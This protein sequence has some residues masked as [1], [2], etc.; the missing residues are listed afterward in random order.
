[1]ERLN[2]ERGDKPKFEL[3]RWEDDYYTADST[4]QEQIVKSSD[5]DIVICIFWKR[6]GS[7]L[8]DQ[9][10]RPDGTNPTGT[11]YEFEMAIE[12][13]S[14]S[15]VR[16]PSLLVYRKTAEVFFSERDLAVERDQY[17]RFKAFW[18]RWFRNEKAHFTAG[19][20]SYDSL[21]AFEELVEAHIHKWL[22]DRRKEVTWTRGSPFVGL[23]AFSPEQAEVFFGR[24][25]ETDRVRARFIAN[26]IA[27]SKFLLVQGPSGSGKS[28]LVRA[29]V[30]PRLR[31]SDPVTGLPDLSMTVEITPADLLSGG[32]DWQAGLASALF[33]APDLGATLAE[34]DFP[35]PGAL[36]KGIRDRGV[37][38]AA[39][40]GALGR[41][42]AAAGRTMGLLIVLDQLEEVFDWP[43]EAA[44][45][46]FA[47]LGPLMEDAPVHTIATMRSEYQHRAAGLPPLAA[48]LGLDGLRDPGA[49]V[50]TIS[51]APP[52]PA[53]LREMI[54]APAAAAGLTYEGTKADRPPLARRIEEAVRVTALPALQL[55]LSELYE[56]RSDMMLTHDA[57]DALG[58]VSGVMAN[59]GELTLSNV[60]A[61]ERAALPKLMRNLVRTGGEG[62]PVV[63]A[64]LARAR[65]EADPAAAGLVKQLMDAGLIVGDETSIRLAHEMLIDAWERLRD[66]VA[67]ERRYIAIRDRLRSLHGAYLKADRKASGLLSGLA[68]DEAVELRNAWGTGALDSHGDGLEDFLRA[69]V[70]ARWRRLLGV[71]MAGI[72]AVLLAAMLGWSVVEQHRAQTT[73]A[74]RAD[75]LAVA[76]EIRGKQPGYRERAASRALAAM[77][78][79]ATPETLAA[80]I[81]A[82]IEQPPQHNLLR[83]PGEIAA[84]TYLPDHRL[85]TIDVAGTLRVDGRPAGTIDIGNSAPRIIAALGADGFVV[86]TSN[87]RV[88]ISPGGLRASQPA[89]HWVSA[90]A[91]IDLARADQVVVSAGGDSVAVWVARDG[92]RAPLKITCSS[93]GEVRCIEA[94][95]KGLEGAAMLAAD[96]DGTLAAVLGGTGRVLIHDGRTV[97]EVSTPPNVTSIAFHDSGTLL[98]IGHDGPASAIVSLV[99]VDQAGEEAG[100]ALRP[101][102]DSRFPIGFQ[103]PSP[104]GSRVAIPCAAADL[105]SLC[106]VDRRSGLIEVLF[107]SDQGIRSAAWSPDGSRLSALHWNG[108]V[109]TWN[110]TT[111]D[112]EGTV[113][114]AAAD[115]LSALAHDPA[116]GRIAV[117]TGAGSVITVDN[118]QAAAVRLGEGSV[119]HLAFIPGGGLAAAH[120]SGV[121]VIDD[122]I[123]LTLTPHGAFTR[124]ATFPNGGLAGVQSFGG[125]VIWSDTTDAEG[126]AIDG[127]FGG[128]LAVAAGDLLATGRHGQI[129]RIR[130]KAVEAALNP[131]PPDDVSAGRSL[132]LHP[133]GR[134]IAVSRGDGGARIFDLAGQRAPVLLPTAAQD[135]NVVRFS[136]GGDR[137]AVLGADGYLHVWALDTDRR[138]TE[139]LLSMQ[140]V[141][142]HFRSDQGRRAAVWIAW[143]S[144]TD[145]AVAT[146]S[147][148]V[149]RVP[150]VAGVVAER[151]AA[152]A[153][154]I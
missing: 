88:G 91:N 31:V 64:R 39:I 92:Q 124:V 131:P 28:S 25:V 93:S 97:T 54:L 53:D 115:P 45:A 82:L 38:A 1:M 63:S 17:E 126:E 18:S 40:R 44:E 102:P 114:V 57:Y 60:T 98:G 135:T 107:A 151:L 144:D 147:G 26:A 110:M 146:R 79:M 7:P 111:R 100:A 43:T 153:K 121:A 6:L 61:A 81:S 9:F 116:T 36:A 19:F 50:A 47:F 94:E 46:L 133:N 86:M 152:S 52:T 22:A 119:D 145:I 96:D 69:S 106:A 12:A 23:R 128:V 34:G 134:D 16:M 41:M 13:A 130:G 24:S 68:L 32:A 83:L 112:D 141:P 105:P 59:R 48:L 136:P 20:H 139:L 58:G 55:L 109:A 30:V 66:L 74:T 108:T 15:E 2:A 154:G 104:E 27:G 72:A 10:R 117:A 5:C 4:F 101:L 89:P 137:I 3:I 77:R 70:A 65:F 21:K 35:D 37:G 87:G 103:A 118:G 85:L 42:T 142:D 127:Y 84:V 75:L 113:L 90:G 125:L 67:D 62:E 143:L 132:D 49:A 71:A 149:L 8:P 129:L 120:A 78:A 73:S 150:V 56:R 80:G 51:I 29:G 140:P 14:A 148:V 11:E 33:D 76:G 122:G 138:S 95:M 99:G 123:A